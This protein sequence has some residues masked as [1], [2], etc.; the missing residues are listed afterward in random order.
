[1][2]DK[3]KRL[4][5]QRPYLAL[6]FI[7]IISLAPFL[8]KPFNM[9]DPLFIWSAREIQANLSNPYGFAVNW[10][11]VSQPMSVVTENP[12]L[13]CYYLSLA[14]TLFGWGEVALHFA[15]LLPA[16]ASVLG[17]YRLAKHFCHGPHLAALA[18][19]FAPGFLVSSTGVMCDVTLLALWLWAVV[20]WVEGLKQNVFWKLAMAALLMTLAMLTKYFGV[21]LIPLLAVYGWLERRKPGRWGAFFL[22]PLTALA[23]YEFLTFHL[24][25]HP[26]FFAA[27]QYS[28][29]AQT[30][31]SAATFLSRLNVITFAGGC[32]V[33]V[34]FCSPFL[35]TWRGLSWFGVFAAG[36]VVLTFATGMISQNYPWLGRNERIF[37]G[38][39]MLVWF[40]AGICLLALVCKELRQDRSPGM[41][42]LAL[43][44]LGTFVFAAFFNWIV[45]VRSVLPLVP[46]MGILLARRLEQN[47]TGL[48][49]GMKS[50]FVLAGGLSLLVAQSDCLQ[51]V[52]VS[53]SAKQ[54]CA[55]NS[56]SRGRIWFQGH[57]GFQ[58]YMQTAGAAA[59]NFNHLNLQ[60]GDLVVTPS[61]NTNLRLI[62]PKKTTL[63]EVETMP[64][65]FCLAT[66]SAALGAGFY[67]ASEGPLP[68]AFGFVPPEMVFVD[69]W[70]ARQ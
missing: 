41:M 57:W 59:I 11:G 2:L 47:K 3:I 44:I 24:Y 5:C 51:A 42:L 69:L 36:F 21:C 29:P 7:T 56:A 6:T 32:S 34:L 70:E 50:G 27:T 55:N 65:G 13:S 68:F 58:Y 16:V 4:M 30:F 54:V 48:T 19:L 35:W 25:G 63:L 64:V 39:Q 18:T 22:I 37:V 61:L 62:D 38:L 33:I 60:P 26:L 45:N 52:A 12:P 8:A 15:Y 46:A 40:V 31:H 14:G 53:R 20:F 43:W 9:D 23:A 49:F 10:Y 1:M 17:T 28:N 67:D 66:G